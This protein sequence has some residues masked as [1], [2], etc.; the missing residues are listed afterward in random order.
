LQSRRP[1]TPDGSR[2]SPVTRA[3]AS[4]H[5][6]GPRLLEKLPL[7]AAA[8]CVGGVGGGGVGP[9]G[10]GAGVT[11]VGAG[12]GAGA[13]GVTGAVAWPEPEGVIVHAPRLFVEKKSPHVPVKTPSGPWVN[14]A[15]PNPCPLQPQSK[16]VPLAE[17]ANVPAG[18]EQCTLVEFWLQVT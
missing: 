13:T 14:T 7:R 6:I 17:Q 15:R 1:V 11:V 3:P 4:V 12:V 8:G 9:G 5:D 18:N 16:R 10:A 2:K